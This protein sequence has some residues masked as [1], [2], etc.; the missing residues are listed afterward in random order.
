MLRRLISENVEPVQ[1]YINDSDYFF[2]RYRT[3]YNFIVKRSDAIPTMKND[4][5][6]TRIC[7]V[8]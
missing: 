1:N 6:V 8:V 3:G 2:R 4:E 5:C 7:S